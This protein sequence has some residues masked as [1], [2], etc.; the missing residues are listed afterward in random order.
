MSSEER[1]KKNDKKRKEKA[2]ESGN[3]EML[4]R[5]IYE[6]PKFGFL[7]RKIKE[8]FLYSFSTSSNDNLQKYNGQYYYLITI[9][10]S[11]DQNNNSILLKAT[12]DSIEKNISNLNKI[13]INLKDILIL[14]F[15]EEIK[16]ND[17]FNRE[18]DFNLNTKDKDYIYIELTTKNMLNEFN[19]IA[20]TKDKESYIIENLEFFYTKIVKDLL[21]E[22]NG[23]IYSTI[24]KNGIDLKENSLSNLF[25]CLIGP[26]LN[27]NSIAI[28]TIETKS[29]GLFANIQQYENIHF[30]LYDLNYYDISCSVPINS[31]FNTM[32]INKNLL[33]YLNE[34]YN[35]LNKN[36]SVY[37]HDYFMGIFLK[38]KFCNVNFIP[39]VSGY[40]YY[41]NI[42][43]SEYM[44]LY[45]EK[46]SGYYSNFFNL[47]KS[48]LGQLNLINK[49]FLIFQLIGMI[50]QFI[51]PSLSTLVI[52]SIFFECFNIND[53]RTAFFFTLI[54]ITFLFFAG[55]TFKRSS[56]ISQMK[57]ITFF[58]FI[59]FE[60]FYAF[61]LI[62]SIFA[63]NN[64]KKNKNLD[65]YKFNK[66][67]ISLLI[68]FNFIFGILPM[69]FSIGKILENIV[70]MIFY[71]FLGSP[72]SNSVFL[73]SYLFNASYKSGGIKLGDKNGFFLL[74]FF[75]SNIFFGSLIFFLTNRS[76]RVN[77]VLILS[78]I[79]TVYNFVKQ[80]SIVLRILIYEKK[81]DQY[82]KDQNII[83]NI[84]KDL[85]K[86]KDENYN[87]N[88]NNNNNI[89]DNDNDREND[90]DNNN[91]NYENN[92]NNNSEREDTEEFK[93]SP[94]LNNFEEED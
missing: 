21:K 22:N 30:N 87:D 37:Y 50:I 65:K 83:Q 60:L 25:P 88:D 42:D 10:I 84:S 13:G 70:N 36:C 90:N 1:E 74:V 51:Y 17:L 14:L 28:P 9:M 48:I 54:Y 63:M 34:F 40:F 24:L 33:N 45:V 8:S 92:N 56:S 19:L 58:F 71:L 69:F 91:N 61:I 12:L 47:F 35:N 78:I 39:F 59:F 49:L 11:D 57:L 2:K 23:F 16:T 80:I 29:K 72:S 76:K 7:K 31:D 15:F 77:C 52:Y 18:E 53:N 66:I 41:E 62:C 38:N 73:M 89:I 32:K 81:F 46:Y 4:K 64:I 44:S 27:K 79:F 67:A 93:E 6:G 94:K 85:K 86:I 43:Y 26:E 75:L 3:E 55:V 82:P 20:F 5:E 68:I